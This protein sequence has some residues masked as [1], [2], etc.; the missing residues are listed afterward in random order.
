MRTDLELFRPGP[1]TVMT[2]VFQLLSLPNTSD[3]LKNLRITATAAV[4]DGSGSPRKVARLA[5]ESDSASASRSKSKAA[6]AP[7]SAFPIQV[8]II[9][10]YRE[11]S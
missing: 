8:K 11:L 3:G 9:G 7:K 2:S 6:S 5:A 1:R 10:D 4:E